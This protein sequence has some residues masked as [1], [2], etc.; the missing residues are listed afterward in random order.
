MKFA[1]IGVLASALL[2]SACGSDSDNDTAQVTRAQVETHFANMAHAMVQDS[3]TASTNLKTAVTTLVATP[4]DENLTAAKAAYKSL[5]LPYQQFEI[6]RFDV[7][8]NHVTT[9]DT[10]PASDGGLA[11]VDDWEGQVNAWPLDEALIDYVDVNYGG[12][13]PVEANT[14]INIINATEGD[15]AGTIDAEFLIGLNE[16][17]DNGANVATGIHAIE[18]LLWGQDQHTGEGNLGTGERPASDYAADATCTSG[19]TVNGSATICTRR[20]EYLTA[21]TDLLVADLTAMEVEWNVDTAGLTLR[22]DFIQRGDGLERVLDSM[23]D[24][25]IGEL[26][27][28]RM[29][30]AILLNSTEDEHDCFSDLTHVAIYGNALG[31]ID[32]YLGTYTRLDGSQ[33][34]GASISDLVKQNDTAA[35]TNI[36][37]LLDTVDAEF[38][39]ILTAADGGKTFDMLVGSDDDTIVK[40]AIIALDALN[41]PFSSD[42]AN[43][44]NVSLQG[45]DEG[46]CAVGSA[47]AG[48]CIATE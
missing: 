11:N 12:E 5:R 41:V 47:E 4:S 17:A 43:A 22:S 9:G 31:V 34:T 45:I 38:Q 40:E 6:T 21:V 13:F 1:P 20:G 32:A 30:V 46:T 24:M 48:N 29:G 37:S 2:L 23:G 7:A 36:R 18:F 16:F 8:N 42:V 19:A 33:M 39:D 25:A 3:L 15:L 26:A 28:E 10:G 35:D 27:S 44:L 14:S